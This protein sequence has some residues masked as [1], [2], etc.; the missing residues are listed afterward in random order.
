MVG[1]QFS[2]WHTWEASA[3]IYGFADAKITQ[4]VKHDFPDQEMP[5]PG[6]PALQVFAGEQNFLE[7]ATSTC[8]ILASHMESG[9]NHSV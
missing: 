9:S 4:S 8:C 2:A 3:N 7:L 6:L 5:L 1:W